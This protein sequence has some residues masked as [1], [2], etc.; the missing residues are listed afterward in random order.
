[1]KVVV[2]GEGGRKVEVSVYLIPKEKCYEINIFCGLI[3]TR[4]SYRTSAGFTVKI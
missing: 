4:T 2:L 3:E 1:M